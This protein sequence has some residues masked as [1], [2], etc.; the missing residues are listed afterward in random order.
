MFNYRY[1]KEE[2]KDN[3]IE[4]RFKIHLP[5]KLAR[6]LHK[7]LAQM[8]NSMQEEEDNNND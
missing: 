1:M 8:V 7:A 4:P 2:D 3:G 6:P 5:L